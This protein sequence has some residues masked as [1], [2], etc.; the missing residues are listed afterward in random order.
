MALGE[1][2]SGGDWGKAPERI[3][4]VGPFCL[5]DL[6]PLDP[7]DVLDLLDSP[8]ALNL[9]HGVS[10]LNGLNG[11]HGWSEWAQLDWVRVQHPVPY[12]VPDHH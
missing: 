6:S 7:L 3:E 4:P 2:L 8:D 5:D 1:P 10:R 9:L 11:L 12:P